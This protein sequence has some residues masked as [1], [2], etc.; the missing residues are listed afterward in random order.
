MAAGVHAESSPSASPGGRL[1]LSPLRT[2]SYCRKEKEAA[3]ATQ[4]L[5]CSALAEMVSMTVTTLTEA[6]SGLQRG[7]TGSALDGQLSLEDPAMASAGRLLLGACAGLGVTM[8]SFAATLSGQVLVPLQELHQRILAEHARKREDVVRLRQHELVCS[9]ALTDALQRRDRARSGLQ[10]AMREQDRKGKEHSEKKK[11]GWFAKRRSDE[12]R[13]DSKLKRAACE[14]TAAIEELAERTDEAAVARLRA[15]E[16]VRALNAA[17][18]RVDA[19]RKRLLHVSLS[20]CA[21][22]WEEA[23]AALRDTSQRF[24]R[25]AERLQ[26][27]VQAVSLLHQECNVPELSPEG[28][29][30]SP[31]METQVAAS[32][33]KAAA[34]AP[35]PQPGA[36]GMP[37]PRRLSLEVDGSDEDCA[38]SPFAAPAAMTRQPSSP[39]ASAT[40][41]SQLHR[42]SGSPLSRKGF[43][44]SGAL[45]AGGDED[46]MPQLTWRGCSNPFGSDEESEE[47]AEGAELA[48]PRLEPIS[49][50][51]AS[52]RDDALARAGGG[53]PQ[54]EG[55][56]Q[57][58]QVQLGVSAAAAVDGQCDVLHRGR[59]PDGGCQQPPAG[60]KAPGGNTPALTVE[61]YAEAADAP[62]DEEVEE[63]W[64]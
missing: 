48:Q 37:L 53:Q 64:C 41:R 62:A 34:S 40:P 57:D 25:E 60:A 14:Q 26:L 61:D 17:Y 15:E 42:S 35:A 52:S 55:A 39:S 13:E 59:P 49:A 19:E 43:P 29:Q 3:V 16:S 18:E 33:D 12:V 7:T 56:Q 47:P 24:R 31:P 5:T 38:N 8:I 4:V 21:G 45:A 30:R 2:S 9:N 50:W 1:G 54:R 10:G 11:G 63:Q 27:W 32:G 46:D 23:A 22:P 44:S 6:G 51:G 58:A 20:R 28:S 36:E